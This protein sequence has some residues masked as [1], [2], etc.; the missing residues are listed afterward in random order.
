ML[1]H[2]RIMVKMTTSKDTAAQRAFLSARL[3]SAST[4]PWALMHSPW[5]PHQRIQVYSIAFRLLSL[6]AIGQR[7]AI[8]RRGRVCSVALSDSHAPSTVQSTI[9]P[10]SLLCDWSFLTLDRRSPIYTLIA[11]IEWDPL[12]KSSCGTVWERGQAGVR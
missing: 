7:C 5:A 11:S 4:L 12:V 2:S 10:L 6:I 3:A 8:V 1:P 9:R